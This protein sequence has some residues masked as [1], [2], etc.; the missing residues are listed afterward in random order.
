M[1]ND[2][3]KSPFRLVLIIGVPLL[4]LSLI[5]AFLFT[6]EPQSDQVQ[7]GEVSSF[8]SAPIPGGDTTSKNGPQS[9]S[10]LYA[11][12][13]AAIDEQ[14][15]Q[16]QRSQNIDEIINGAKSPQSNQKEQ[17]EYLEAWGVNNGKGG[18][19]PT[20]QNTS[21]TPKQKKASSQNN[22]TAPASVT[23]AAPVATAP[24]RRS[25]FYGSSSGGAAP[26]AN[27]NNKSQD[28]INAVVHGDYTVKTGQTIK[29]RLVEDG[30]IDGFTIPK[31][32]IV[33]GVININNER[34]IV[35]ISSVKVGS[36]IKYFRIALYDT[37]GVEGIYIPG[38]VN[39]QIAQGATQNGVS[40][41]TRIPVVGGTVSTGTSQKVQDPT[42]TIPTGYKVYLKKQT[43]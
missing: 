5:V 23:P 18:T 24:Q 15:R 40:I 34:V 27:S 17:D 7:E 21:A 11:E 39:Q 13:K 6:G 26:A 19:I 2:K 33:S 8:E 29:I 31:N 3:K 37:D 30:I 25:S 43:D 9:K 22:T 38:G 20:P 28:F 16:H 42:V 41:S 4:V 36:E 12:N 10:D 35:V 32:T 14:T 1:S